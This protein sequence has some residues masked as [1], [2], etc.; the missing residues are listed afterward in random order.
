MEAEG[1]NKA[2]LRMEAA[3]VTAMPGLA[4][5]HRD[6]ALLKDRAEPGHGLKPGSKQVPSPEREQSV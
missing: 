2:T 3:A 6:C 4:Q 5:D 1:Q